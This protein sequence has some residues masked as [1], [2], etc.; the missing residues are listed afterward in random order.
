MSRHTRFSPCIRFRLRDCHP[1]SYAFPDVSAFTCRDFGLF[2]VRS[3]LLG[4]SRLI[5]FP[6]GTEMF[7]FS[8]FAFLCGMALMCRVAPFGHLRLLRLLPACRSFSQVSASFIASYCQGI[9]QMPF[10]YLIL[11]CVCE[12]LKNHIHLMGLLLHP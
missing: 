2:P 8:R 11:L 3:P 9:H 6:R 10:F 7:H 4:E 1:L 5:S 12:I